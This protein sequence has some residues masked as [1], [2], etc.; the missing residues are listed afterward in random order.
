MRKLA[1]VNHANAVALAKA[2]AQV[3]GLEVITPSFFNEFTIRTPKPG[4]AA[5][6]A[7]ADRGII[8][9]VP[10]ARLWPGAPGL[11]NLIVVAA[12]EVTTPNDIAAFRAALNEVLHG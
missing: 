12:T 1:A 10:A 8:G 2:L 3:P 5:I 4:S 11:Q 6:D 7:L 9:G